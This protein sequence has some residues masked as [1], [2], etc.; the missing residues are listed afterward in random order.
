M[1]LEYMRLLLLRACCACCAIYAENTIH[2]P[3]LSAKMMYAL[4][5]CRGAPSQSIKFECAKKKS[6]TEIKSML[7]PNL[8]IPPSCAMY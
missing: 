8:C 5:L 2:I 1:C 3:F 6:K 7:L 4:Q